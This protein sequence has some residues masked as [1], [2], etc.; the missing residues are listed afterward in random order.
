MAKKRVGYGSF[1]CWNCGKNIEKGKRKCP[2]CEAW[3]S[4]KSKYEGLPETG[5]GGIG[6]SEQTGHPCF[7]KYVKKYR[8]YSFIWLAGVSILISVILLTV[9]DIEPD[10][11]GLKILAIILGII[12]FVG[13][14]FLFLLNG[15][16]KPDWEGVVEDKTI[17]QKTR[18][19][20][21]SDGN[22]YKERYTQ[23]TVIIRKQDGSLYRISN[24]DDST[25]YDYYRIGD[26]VK[27]HG[28]KYLK[29][30]EKYDKSFDSVLYCAS[31][32]RGNDARNNFCE[33][34][35]SVILKAA[36]KS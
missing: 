27:Y 20:K 5:A 15:R 32:K 25:K 29:Y 35:G 33:Y 2:Y 36:P 16:N 8:K 34:C 13:I 6:W 10:S 17:E 4:G 31:C 19:N 21:D 26:Y 18:R 24:D 7:K 9:G 1:Y 22:Y 28:G 14:L 11:E 12:W 23:Y 3:Y 30:I